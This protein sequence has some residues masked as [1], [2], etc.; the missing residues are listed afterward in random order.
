MQPVSP[1]VFETERLYMREF[2][3]DDAPAVFEYA[4]N[5]ENTCFLPFSPEPPEEVERFIESR[6]ASQIVSPR[7]IWDLA[8]CL[9]ETDELIGSMGLTLKDDMRQ[10]ELGYIFNMRF[11]HMGY[12]T[13]A[14]RGFLRFGFLGLDLHRVYARCDDKNAASLAVMERIGMRREAHFIKD[15]YTTVF[16]KKGWRSHYHCAILQKE[17][18]MGLPDGLHSPVSGS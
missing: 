12:A 1:V 16:A 4:G 9:K 17:Y 18:L 15:E 10:A 13:E 3:K 2:V 14:A 7:R 5:V 11:W 6:L 8:V